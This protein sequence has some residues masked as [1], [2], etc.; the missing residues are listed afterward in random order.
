MLVGY[1]SVTISL[2]VLSQNAIAPFTKRTMAAA[3][4]PTERMISNMA[5][6]F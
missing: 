4:R 2:G 3:K 6:F 1:G 5:C